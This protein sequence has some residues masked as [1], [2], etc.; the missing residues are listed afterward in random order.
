MPSDSAAVLEGVR[1]ERI[2]IPD[3]GIELA[4]LDWGGSG[5]PALL[6]HANGFC[7]ALWAPVAE[8]LRGHFRVFALDA[9]GHGDSSK[10]PPRPENYDWAH[11]GSDA[12]AVAELLIR[13]HGPLAL[14]LGHSFG[15][16]ALALAGIARPG[17]FQRL[18]LLDPIVVPADPAA[19]LRASRGPSLAA[20]ARRRRAVWESRAQARARWAGHDTFSGW[21]PAVL[22][23]Y[24]AEGLRDR[25]DGRVEL[26]CPREVEAA[27]FEDSTS[28]DLMQGA[29]KLDIPTLVVWA[30]RG[31]FPRDHFERLAARMQRAEVRD[32]PTGHFVPMED[33]DFVAA[34]VLAAQRSTG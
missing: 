22:E 17:L 34:L 9:R 29:A 24:L 20:G 8:R 1:C 3:A 30:S 19:R 10:P 25:D 26:K 13:R 7:A 23:L 14:G 15:G 31:H 27:V 6:H 21:E 4:L 28:V 11:F 16:T 18:V 2:P 32:A 12:R 33:P 5:P